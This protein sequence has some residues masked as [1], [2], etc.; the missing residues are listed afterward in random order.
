MRLELFSNTLLQSDWFNDLDNLDNRKVRDSFL[1]LSKA[2]WNPSMHPWHDFSFPYTRDRLRHEVVC[3]LLLT[4]VSDRRRLLHSLWCLKCH[5]YTKQ[6]PGLERIDTSCELSDSL[7]VI[8]SRLGQPWAASGSLEQPSLSV[9]LH[10]AC[11]KC[12]LHY[13]NI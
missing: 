10:C 6:D 5:R 11:V 1:F 12:F 2:W 3:N 8:P 7:H 9:I 4:Y 13:V